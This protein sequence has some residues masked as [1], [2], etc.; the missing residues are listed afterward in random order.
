MS[1]QKLRMPMQFRYSIFQPLYRVGDERRWELA[2]WVRCSECGHCSKM[3][4]GVPPARCPKCG[5]GEVVIDVED[6]D[7]G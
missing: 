1:K 6:G 4:K 2:P 7:D 5:L 3:Q